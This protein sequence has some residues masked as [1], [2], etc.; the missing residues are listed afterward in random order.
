MFNDYLYNVRSIKVLGHENGQVGTLIFN[1]QQ[2]RPNEMDDVF[3]DG[4]IEAIND[5]DDLLAEDEAIVTV[6]RFRPD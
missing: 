2:Q 4:E 3:G 1:T 6:K 5:G